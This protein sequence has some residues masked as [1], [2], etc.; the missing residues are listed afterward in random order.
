MS[1][2]DKMWSMVFGTIPMEN[3]GLVKTMRLQHKTFQSLRHM[4]ETLPMALDPG[5]KPIEP[6]IFEDAGE[7]V[8]R[9]SG[10]LL[11]AVG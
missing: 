3:T 6:M 4:G 1:N 5:E 10:K 9:L 2:Q 8:E 7:A 11:T